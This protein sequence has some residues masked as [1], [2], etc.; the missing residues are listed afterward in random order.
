MHSADHKIWKM[1]WTTQAQKT[2]FKFDANKEY[3]RDDWFKENH[4][5]KL[6]QK[7]DS[8]LVTQ[9]DMKV[10]TLV[11]TNNLILLLSFQHFFNFLNTFVFSVLSFLFLTLF[12]AQY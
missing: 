1:W 6:H 10:Q 3:A 8:N 4:L 7:N 5:E 12:F 2:D 9:I 11:H